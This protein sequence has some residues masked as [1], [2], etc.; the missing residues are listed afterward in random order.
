[1]TNWEILQHD[2]VTEFL[3]SL[4]ERDEVRIRQLFLL[5]QEVGP[6]IREPHSKPTNVRGLFELRKESDKKLY[7]AFYFRDGGKFIVAHAFQKKG[8]KTPRKE[9]EIAKKRMQ[10]YQK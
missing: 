7:R 3:S 5:L 2:S 8:R 10:Q 6:R 1:M 9:I 4:P